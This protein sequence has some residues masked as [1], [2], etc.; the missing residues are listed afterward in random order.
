MAKKTSKK[1]NRKI[2]RSARKTVGVL[3]L[4][5]ALIVA[6]IPTPSARADGDTESPGT[7]SV[8]VQ[9]YPTASDP[10]DYPAGMEREPITEISPSGDYK[11]L[12]IYQT[13]A[14]D[15]ELWQAY[16]IGLVNISG[17]QTG[18]ITKYNPVFQPQDGTLIIRPNVVTG[19]P[20]FTLEE[21]TDFFKDNDT[22]L[23]ESELQKYYTSEYDQAKRQYDS[24]YAAYEREHAKW[25]ADGGSGAGYSEPTFA[26]TWPDS[27][28]SY[29][30]QN[31]SYE[32]RLIYFCDSVNNYQVAGDRN[33]TTIAGGGY[34]LTPVTDKTVATPTPDASGIISNT[35]VYIPFNPSLAAGGD[36]SAGFY[37]TGKYD[38]KYIG[39]RAFEGATNISKIVIPSEI[40]QIGD[41][42]FEDAAVREVTAYSGT[43]G[44]R[45]FKNCASLL[46]V[47]IDAGSTEVIGTECFYGCNRLSSIT[48]PRTVKRIGKGSFAYCAGLN[49]ID[50]SGIDQRL[51]ID[52]Y[53]FYDCYSIS[54]V[55]F[56]DLTTEIGDCVFALE[57][58][59]S[60]SWTQITF[61]PRIAGMGE[62]VLSGRTNLTSVV[63]P[64]DY[65]KMNPAKIGK[66]FFRN[67]INLKYVEFPA[68][69]G[70]C[71]YA[72]FG[73]DTF[74]DVLTEGFYIRGPEKNGAGNT[75]SPRKCA[76]ESGITY[77]FNDNPTDPVNG[78]DH[79]E[80]STGAY[81]FAI[82]DDGV[83]TQCI[84]LKPEEF[85]DGVTDPD[86][87]E[88]IT[89]PGQIIVPPNVGTITV[90][91]IGD[92]CFSDKDI[93][94]NLQILKIEDG[95]QISLIE[96]N[97]FKGFPE[98]H[99]VYVGNSV[100]AIGAGAF[101]DCKKLET[102][103]FSPPQ[104]GGYDRFTIGV[105]AFATGG[106]KLTF[107]GD[108][109]ENYAPFKWAMD[110][111]MNESKRIGVCYRSGT[112]ENP[113]LT[114][115]RDNKTGDV[116][117]VGYPHYD[118]LPEELRNKY[119]QGGVND[120][121]EGLSALEYDQ[122]QNVLHVN[123]PAGVTS[124]DVSAYLQESTE[125]GN[126]IRTYLS[127][128]PYY[129][130]YRKYGLFNG[131][132]GEGKG[133]D[134]EREYPDGSSMEQV[135]KG[136]DRIQTVTMS[137]VKFLPDRAFESCENLEGVVLGNA[138]EDVGTAPFT[139]CR[140]LLS[141]G[142]NSIYS[143]ENGIIYRANDTGLT[144]IECLPAR[145]D[146][147][148]GNDASVNADTDGSI[149]NV[150]QIA[151]GAFEN[152]ASISE[153]DLS[154]A[155]NL[156]VIPDNCFKGANDL[157][158]V[159]LPESVNKI[160]D[161]AF[162]REKIDGEK[163]GTLRVTIPAVEVD[164]ADNAFDNVKTVRLLSYDDSAVKRYAARKDYFFVPLDNK[165]AVRFLD[166][167]GAQIGETQ[168]IE[169]GRAAEA[170][171]D[172]KRDGYVFTGWSSDD[173]H[174]VTQDL[175]IIA[176]YTANALL[177]PG[178][179][180]PGAATPGAGTPGA[181]TPGAGTPGAGTPGAGTPGAG[182]PGAGT[183]GAGTP[184]AG[185]PGA[186]G[187]GANSNQQYRLTVDNGSGDGMYRAGTSVIIT[188]DAPPAGQRFDR[189]TSI[190]SD[191]NITSATSSITTITMPSHDMT[192]V[193]NYTAASSS[194]NGTNNGNNTNISTNTNANG[195]SSPGTTVDITKP[196]ISDPDVA[197][198]VVQGSTD[199]FVVKITDTAEARAAV[200][201]A[202]INEYG[203]LDGL[204]YFAMDI[205][206]YDSTGTVKIQ[207]TSNLAVNITM[208]IPD[209]LRQY[210]G[211]NQVAGVVNGNVLDKL[212]PRFTTINGIPCV[213]FTATHFSPYTVFVDTS[214]LSA[215]VVD[216]T[217]KTGDLI[218]PKWF[219]AIALACTSMILLLKKDKKQP[220]TA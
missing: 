62:Y 72:E 48:F 193:A 5:M 160:E 108:I 69:N 134:D 112:P 213:S 215:G 45:A 28:I 123:I 136:N 192:I 182:T 105:N 37:G 111:W 19:Y 202:L 74:A 34:S 148:L 27:Y 60:G 138:M 58:G 161:T 135:A 198:A 99:T 9:T 178:A 78:T 168:Y 33:L 171:A 91:G 84:L 220:K 14:G 133:E 156:K 103:V 41:S 66:G 77:V 201:A 59:I 137:T 200:E 180:T 51:V 181:G 97:A 185:T 189:W 32:N 130:T 216:H 140:N 122:L 129:S 183:P 44:N 25:E 89:P 147:R 93:K 26:K 65:G 117:L 125:N 49:S 165:Y 113:N 211:N 47:E 218:H 42:A 4:I 162:A 116:T 115:M 81:R 146:G 35:T 139:G 107:Y 121:G 190:A 29:E 127:D 126:N 102:V 170:P 90:T 57:S 98:L 179:G 76:W 132:Y 131:Y 67:C 214:N 128:D 144:I 142:G 79:W 187:Q 120:S 61:P 52:D 15:Y 39:E 56:C 94:E 199:N 95:G 143:C 159:I 149:P 208:P 197:S 176:Q 92:E 141:V 173:Y 118:E 209:E 87:G 31:L 7:S 30:A 96:E 46:K 82:D 38:V 163:Q 207:D 177:S 167:N 11:A 164:I 17:S 70:S 169:E 166:Y 16:N 154:R 101:E 6:L 155:E 83:L 174:K 152:C 13:S 191:F 104:N 158:E 73:E 119:E 110:N 86:T 68:G 219:L 20:K 21:I 23:T 194:G 206:L 18:V 204:R 2:K 195:N 55:D 196:G 217:P 212:S 109:V 24:E 186:G 106:E 175:T 8:P 43:I 22:K 54:N 124:I 157:T 63:M 114:V 75:A 172:P 36:V 100:N 210:A 150:T 205:S 3:T 85:K 1:V 10:D 71:G 153:V 151:E 80:V 40:L 12:M 88:Y 50:M 64:E 145:G 203:T 184:G 188:A 53:A